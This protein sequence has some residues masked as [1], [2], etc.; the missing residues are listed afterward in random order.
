MT[1]NNYIKV[2]E[3]EEA[4]WSGNHVVPMF[5]K[6]LFCVNFFVVFGPPMEIIFF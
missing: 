2:G 5:L 4:F 3:F 6:V 1:S